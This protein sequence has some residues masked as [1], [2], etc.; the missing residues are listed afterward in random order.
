MPLT[1]RQRWIVQ[2]RTGPGQHPPYM[3]RTGADPMS[4]L[5]RFHEQDDQ[6]HPDCV[7][8]QAA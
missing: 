1:A 4:N 8:P 5:R 7:P 6:L 2:H 3:P